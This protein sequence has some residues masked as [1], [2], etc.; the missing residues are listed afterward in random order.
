MS[1]G[2]GRLMSAGIA[3]ESVRGTAETA[4]TFYIPF[5]E[6]NFIPKDDKITDEQSYGVIEDSIA[7]SIVKEWSEIELGAPL[8][9][10]SFG[11]IL[12]AALG[13]VNT[14]SNPD[15]GGNV[16]DHTFTVSQSSQHQ[17]LT[18]FLDDPIGA[19]DYKFALG[20]LSSLEISYEL[21]KYVTYKAKFMAKKGASATLTPST[22]V[23][24]RFLPQNLTF[25][26]ATNLAGL[27]AASAVAIKKVNITIEKNLESDDVLGS[28]T[29]ADFL[30]KQFSIKGSLEAIWQNEADF[31][32]AAL[33]GTAQAMRID[34]ISAVTIGTAAHPQITIDLAKII[35]SDHS[36]P[37]KLNNIMTQ[38]LSFKALYS[39]TDSKLVTI[40]LTN[41]QTSY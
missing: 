7:Q 35:F 22:T 40:K 6:A 27:T 8:T 39:T 37:I 19:A 5:S 29:P 24:N 9:D 13:S 30:N 18:M 33:A 2:I 26:L 31:K 21:G 16:K 32:T 28:T 36:D 14:A 23:E 4:A 25:K 15:A 12:L 11:L 17:S 34:L 1:K 20:A 41:L 3:K 38:T 10:K